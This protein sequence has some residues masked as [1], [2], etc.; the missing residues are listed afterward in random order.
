M[1]TLVETFISQEEKSLANDAF[2][3]AVCKLSDGETCS[4]SSSMR[5]YVAIVVFESIYLAAFSV[6]LVVYSF[7]PTPAREVWAKQL[8]FIRR[9]LPCFG[10]TFNIQQ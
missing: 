10:R 7:I 4:N 6:L 5:V 2:I 1:F 8:K 9:I 3:F